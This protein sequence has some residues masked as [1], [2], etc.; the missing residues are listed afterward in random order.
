MTW[1]LAD[2]RSDQLGDL[3]WLIEQRE[4][5]LILPVGYGKTPITLAAFVSIRGPVAPI[6]SPR[7]RAL[8][9]STKKIIQLTWGPEI[10]K[11]DFSQ[12]L[13]YA[14]ATG[15]AKAATTAVFAKP[16]ILGLNF[17]RLE[18]FY[19]LV[20][21][22]PSLLPEVLIIDESSK[23]KSHAANRVKRHCGFGGFG[24]GYV[25]RY[26]HRWALSAT[27]TPEGYAGLWPQEQAIS[28]ERRLGENITT[29][30]A[31]YCHASWNGMRMEYK[32]LPEGEKRI[33]DKLAPIL[34]TSKKDK[35]LEL[36]DPIHSR[37]DVPW[38][39]ES[40]EEYKRLEHD[41]ILDIS[42]RIETIGKDAGLHL[43]TPA[44][45][46]AAGLAHVLAPN[47]GVLLNK[48][49]QACSGFVYDR[50]GNARA[51]AG[52]DAKLIALDEFRER[53]G[54]A[55]LVVF[56][57]YR[58]EAKAIAEAHPDFVV[59]LPDSLDA[60]NEGRVPGLCLHPRSA[61]HGVN[62]QYGGHI[63]LWY[64]IPWSYEEWHQANGRLQRT[65]QDRQV[66]IARLNRPASVEGDVWSKLQGKHRTLSRFIEAIRERT[67]E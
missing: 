63:A 36:P 44:D 57:Q 2:F 25:E 1:T 8:V 56:T 35:Y 20:D 58:A 42:E 19:D 4:A 14:M 38:S 13:S 33:D 51:L 18:W 27:P 50:D 3:K 43:R 17:E 66:S 39:E 15:T 59:G 24:K 61:G 52:S 41:F 26:S 40:R 5:L 6:R 45:L 9:I 37:I 29:F 31:R 67:A 7:C 22:D 34:R 11:W 65:G 21:E 10:A 32:V 60:W 30:R 62:L 28:R 23:M 48:L 12:D 47:L 46:E 55:P 49:R 54:D 64:A 16:D 53:I